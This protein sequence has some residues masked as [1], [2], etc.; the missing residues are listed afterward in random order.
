LKNVLGKF[1]LL[2]FL[3]QGGMLPRLRGTDASGN[4][5]KEEGWN[6]GGRGGGGEGEREVER[7][8]Y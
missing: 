1:V 7:E 6:I 2:D 3:K 8:E 5:H 4:Q